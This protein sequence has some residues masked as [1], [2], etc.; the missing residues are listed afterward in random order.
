MRSSNPL[1]LGFTAVGAT[2]VAYVLLRGLLRRRQK[3]TGKV[4]LITGASSG[5]GEALAHQFVKA[6]CSVILAARSI[7]KLRQLK[8]E[9]VEVH[10]VSKNRLSP[11]A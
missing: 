2:A 11:S 8:L 3:L 10:K 9:L 7:E 5:I 4:V 1:Q 6:G